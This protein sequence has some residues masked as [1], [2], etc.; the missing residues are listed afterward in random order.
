MAKDDETL[1][2]SFELSADDID[3]FRARLTD[4]REKHAEAPESQVIDAAA[5]LV[6]EV[7]RKSVPQFVKDSVGKLDPL[8]A[9]LRDSQW[10]LEGDDRA[11]VIG[12]LAYFVEPVD[13]IPDNVPGIGYVDDAIVIQLVS[14]ELVHEIEA[15]AEF[16]DFVAQRARA[17]EAVEKQRD[18]LQ[19]R[20]RRRARR[21]GRGGGGGGSHRAPLSLL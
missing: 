17:D 19:G 3:Y 4:A 12:A 15:Y 7:R 5:S 21:S 13:V 6:E 2:V 18:A 8:I 14:R 10:R 20:M 9:M 16:R 1:S 11:R